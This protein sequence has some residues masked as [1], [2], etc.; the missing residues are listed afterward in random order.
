M[1]NKVI[2]TTFTDPMMGLSYEC[3]PIFRKLETHFEENIEFKHV[4]SGLVRDVMD[5]VN[6]NDLI[7]G[8]E[9]AIKR[10]NVRLAKIYESEESISNMPINMTNFHLFS[11]TETSSIPLNLAYKAVQIIDSKKADLFLY[12]LRYATIVDCRPT[13]QVKEILKVVEKTN[14][15]KDKF[16]KQY[17]DNT[18]K[19][20]LNKDFELLNYYGIHSL[21]AYLIEYKDKKVL[22]KSLI[23]YNSFVSIIYDI[24]EGRIKPKKI[25]KSIELIRTLINKH[26]IIS[27]IEIKEALD[28]TSSNEV[29]SFIEP[30]VKK[31]EI[32][33]IDVYHGKF[34]KKF[35][36]F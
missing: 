16:I 10:Y 17:N 32:Q 6:P 7:Y 11:I 20:E 1:N 4:M 15:D 13:T 22:V 2:I 5:F 19:Q 36:I 31:K 30:L 25:A 28:M 12:N 33:I 3:E 8:K 27:I 9:E 21:P 34:I 18:T 24:T 23:D 29:I 26:S 35:E 14:I